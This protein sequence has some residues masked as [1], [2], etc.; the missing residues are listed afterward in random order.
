MLVL[1]LPAIA[2]MPVTAE[3]SFSIVELTEMCRDVQVDTTALPGSVVLAPGKTIAGNPGHPTAGA[4]WSDGID[5]AALAGKGGIA[6][7][8][9]PHS[10]CLI[11]LISTPKTTAVRFELRS[12]VTPAYDPASWNVW[13]PAQ[14]A[15][16]YPLPAGHRYAQWRAILTSGDNSVTPRVRMV[17]V[18]TRLDI[19]AVVGETGAITV[20]R[21]QNQRIVHG[22]CDGGN[23]AHAQGDI[24]QV[25]NQV[26]M[27]PSFTTAAGTLHLD[28]DT[29]TP[30]FVRYEVRI[31]GK[32]W[33]ESG[34]GMDWLL[35]PDNNI[36]EVRAVNASEKPGIISLLEVNY[37]T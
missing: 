21:F 15:V 1:C 25:C 7:A 20:N 6:P 5:L 9:T 18:R 17:K 33:V 10:V 31:D 12:G 3:K 27:H 19:K 2:D 35:H 13:Q 22:S 36:L 24:D 11:A 14:L 29:E 30:N 26:A 37:A 16:W 8:A 23:T 32:D 34:A 28:F 4:F